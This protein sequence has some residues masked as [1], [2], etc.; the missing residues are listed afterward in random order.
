MCQLII[1]GPSAH[2]TYFRKVKL[3]VTLFYTNNW[4]QSR[5]LVYCERLE[6]A[7]KLIIS[8]N[9]TKFCLC[10]PREYSFILYCLD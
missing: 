9:L 1:I 10:P 5:H 8:N 6:V 7:Y 4:R 2:F 3:V